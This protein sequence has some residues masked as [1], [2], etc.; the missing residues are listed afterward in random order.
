MAA[1][2][3]SHDLRRET[4][5][6]FLLQGPPQGPLTLHLQGSRLKYLNPDERSAAMLIRRALAGPSEGEASPGIWRHPWGLRELRE[7]AP[8]PLILLQEGAT[9]IRTAAISDDVLFILSGHRDPTD[10]ELKEIQDRGAL[11]LSVGPLSV[12]AEH[13]ITLVHNELDRRRA[14]DG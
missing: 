14:H 13:C 1:F 9:D 6:Y 7:H 12:R 8:R 10:A 4:E 5:V 11:P 2:F 3:S